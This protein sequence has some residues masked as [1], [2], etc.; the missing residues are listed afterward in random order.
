[1]HAR[2]RRGIAT[3][4]AAT[5][6]GCTRLHGERGHR[7]F[8]RGQQLFAKAGD[9]AAR[10]SEGM[11]RSSDDEAHD[12]AD[13]SDTSDASNPDAEEADAGTGVVADCWGC[14]TDPHCRKCMEPAQERLDFKMRQ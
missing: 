1:M 8:A 10:S 13:A 7:T 2:R 3:R 4:V 11:R 12:E 6:S 5:D 14:C 9:A